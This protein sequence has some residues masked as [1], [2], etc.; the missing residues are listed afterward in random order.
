[1]KGQRRENIMAPE[2]TEKKMPIARNLAAAG[3]VLVVGACG[4]DQVKP[5][6]EL[7]NWEAE[8][9][10]RGTMAALWNDSAVIHLSEDSVV[11]RC[12]RGGRMKGAGKPPDEEFG[13]DTIRIVIDYK[14][15]PSECGVTRVGL[16]FTVDGNPS[17]R[18]EFAAEVIRRVPGESTFTGGFSGGVKWQLGD[19]AGNCAMA[20]ALIAEGDFDEW[21]GSFDGKLCG[22]EVEVNAVGL[23][24]SLLR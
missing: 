15:M 21:K 12:Q 1:M 9:L 14:F 4:N 8:L 7:R 23:M 11:L 10:L 2:N 19:R 5:G 24:P 18:Y 13:R 22:H 6:N 17:F 3:L 16:E 20:L